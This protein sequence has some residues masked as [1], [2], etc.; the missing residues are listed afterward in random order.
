MDAELWLMLPFTLILFSNV[1]GNKSHSLYFTFITLWLLY[2]KRG[3]KCKLTKTSDVAQLPRSES[4]P[5][6][7]NVK[8]NV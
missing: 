3:K 4:L 7:F 2:I 1:S 5:H 8:P 6:K